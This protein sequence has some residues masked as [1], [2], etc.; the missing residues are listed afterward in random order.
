MTQSLF[1]DKTHKFSKVAFISARLG[2]RPEEWPVEV[3]RESYKQL[4]F[5]KLYETEVELDQVDSSRGYGVGKLLVWPARTEKVHSARQRQLL[6][7]PIIIRDH[8]LSPLDVY[9][10]QG[11]MHPMDQDAVSSILMNPAIIEARMAKKTDMGTGLTQSMTPPDDDTQYFGN[12]AV[13]K[14]SLLEVITPTIDPKD[15]R[16]LEEKMSTDYVA[17]TFLAS[18]VSEFSKVASVLHDP[19]PKDTLSLREAARVTGGGLAIKAG[20]YGLLKEARYRILESLDE[21]SAAL[22][23]GGEVVYVGETV[24]QLPLREVEQVKTASV[25]TTLSGSAEVTGVIVPRVVGFD[26]TDWGQS[27]FLSNDS[28]AYQEKIAAFKGTAKVSL[29]SSDPVSR[30]AFMFKDAGG[31]AV[32]A[33]IKVAAYNASADTLYGE[34]VGSGEFVSVRRVPGLQKLTKLANEVYLPGDASYIE[35]GH[36]AERWVVQRAEDLEALE[37][38]KVANDDTVHVVSDGSVFALRGPNAEGELAERGLM[39][40]DE[41]LIALQSLGVSGD[42]AASVIKVAM[43][44]GS[45][46]VQTRKKKKKVAKKTNAK[47]VEKIADLIRKDLVDELS[48][49]RLREKTASS[50]MSEDSIDAVLSLRFVTPEN[51]SIYV[52]YLPDLEDAANQLAEI[53]VASRLGMDTI[54]ESAARN[55]MTQVNSVVRCL[56]KLRDKIS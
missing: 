2:D 34:L 15:A 38:V 54:S 37:R 42:D 41:A 16:D 27:F 52:G 55:A 21:V 39:E 22:A 36:L 31:Y 20:E 19:Y 10:H 13:K 7:V 47:A 32:T 30:G 33:P 9:S 5:L 3:I 48:I 18:R 8:K 29:E 6:A 28:Y 44:C 1:I 43:G 26:G 17:R 46:P 11:K 25:R 53:L 35:L 49:L 4:P 14:A 12:Q 51:A 24:K 23:Q 50:K 45:A 40:A 56:R